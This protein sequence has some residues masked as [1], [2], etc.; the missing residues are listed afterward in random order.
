MSKA[1]KE[2]PKKEAEKVQNQ[3]ELEAELK[4]VRSQIAEQSKLFALGTHE[5]LS[6]D[7]KAAASERLTELTAQRDALDA[8][9]AEA[10]KK[11]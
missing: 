9:L 5:N 3:A 1:Q 7:E 11:V 4:E 6:D 2:Q 10:P 8:R